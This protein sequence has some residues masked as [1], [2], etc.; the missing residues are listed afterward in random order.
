VGSDWLPEHLRECYGVEVVGT[1]ELDVGVFRVDRADGPSWVARV[2]PAARPLAE[3]EGDAKVLKLL[4]SGG[5][6]AERCAVDDA[7]S[8]HDGQGVLVTEFVRA[9]ER[10]AP[11]R[12]FAIL[13]AL[14]GRLHARDGGKFRAG[15]AW[16][17]VAVAGGPSA[18][19]DGALALLDGVDV[20]VKHRARMNSIREWLADADDGEGLPEAFVHPD[21]VPSNAIPVGDRLTIVDWTGAGRAPRLHSLAWLL[22]VAGSRSPRLLDVTLSRYARHATLQPEE[23]TRLAG[24]MRVRPLV[25]DCWAL[26]HGR[27]TVPEAAERMRQTAQHASGI[28]TRVRHA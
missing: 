16:H 4:S 14:L 12:T 26:R 23:L 7:V 27:L 5:F 20:P 9:D 11:G 10:L 24:I 3:V 28:A 19:I 6:P 8:S 21:L 17:H 13:G 25:L 2:F 1:A 22:W 15:G 18:E